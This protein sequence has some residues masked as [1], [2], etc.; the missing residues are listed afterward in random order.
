[1]KA[2]KDLFFLIQSLSKAEKKAFKLWATRSNAKESN[3]YVRLF[4]YITAQEEYDESALKQAFA[5]APFI[6]NFSVAKA[7]LYQSILASL[8]SSRKASSVEMALRRALDEIEILDARG[9]PEQARKVLRRALQLAQDQELLPYQAE[10]RRWQR[11]LTDLVR[12]RGQSEPLI[13][14]ESAELEALHLLRT[15]AELHS[16]LVR[17]RN[18]FLSRIDVRKSSVAQEL[19]ALMANP[20]LKAS[21]AQLPFFGQL[22]YHYIHAIFHRLQGRHEAALQ[23]NRKAVHLWNGHPK[24][25]RNHPK[26]YLNALTTYLDACLRLFHFE[27][28]LQAL[29]DL[30]GISS[31]NPRIQ[32]RAFYLGQH[33]ELRFA[34]NT[35]Q[36]DRGMAQRQPIEAGLEKYRPYLNKNI[37]V[38]LRYNLLVTHFLAGEHPA[39]IQIAQALLGRADPSMRQDIYDAA[40]LMELVGHYERGNWDVLE[41]LLRSFERRL[42]TRPREH[43][44][45]KLILRGLRK[46][47]DTPL[48]KELAVFESLKISVEAMPE[49]A[50]IAGRT[51]LL[52]WVEGKIRG[53][54]IREVLEEQGIDQGHTK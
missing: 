30:L 28:F 26:Q 32:A 50:H 27:E 21:P 46:L 23:H 22:F 29:P 4:D 7:Y 14:L 19:H 3:N 35:A 12:L 51:E 49:A 31:T 47:I 48:G 20:L 42:R 24:V 9:L 45:E 15:E 39:S 11:R 36:F 8:R 53:M 1:M 25:T 16:L 44:Y 18:I 54:A 33:L 17:I 40:R 5:G 37:E 52:L 38:T 10:L 34:N 43:P 13:A 2:S 41:S 6:A